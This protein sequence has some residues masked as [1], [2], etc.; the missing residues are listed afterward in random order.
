MSEVLE[1]ISY[2]AVNLV[3]HPDEV[4]IQKLD[5]D[6]E[7]VYRLH[8]HE[9]DLGQVIGK[10]GQTARAVRAVLQAVGAKRNRY[11]GFEIAEED[12]TES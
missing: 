7:E 11:Y 8:V 3:D 6:G 5:R 10:G 9:D 4:R 2:I 1:L 12:R